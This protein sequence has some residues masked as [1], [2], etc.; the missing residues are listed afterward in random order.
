MDGPGHYRKAEQLL[1]H[2]ASMLDADVA[3]ELRADLIQRQAAV[4]TMAH[5]HALLAAAAAIG[6]SAT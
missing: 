1:G 2:A 6:L 3:P 4:A 5:A